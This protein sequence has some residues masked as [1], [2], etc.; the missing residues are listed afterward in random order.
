MMAKL[1][2]MV[3][4]VRYISVIVLLL[5][6]ACSNT[7]KSTHEKERPETPWQSN[8]AYKWG[9][10]SLACTANDTDRFNPRPT[11]TSR[12]LALTWTAIFD[13]WSRYD[14]NAIPLY[15]ASA[16]RQPEEK[17]TL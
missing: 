5:T 4:A 7:N 2:K 13:A 12:I 9:E 8:I 14:D 6:Q 1:H 11:V 10:I 3:R 16:K 17:R 15:L